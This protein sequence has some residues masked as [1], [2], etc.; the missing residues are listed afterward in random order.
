MPTTTGGQTRLEIAAIAAR[1]TLI[2]INTYDSVAAANN[3]TATHTRA[4]ADT[5]TPIQGKGTGNYLDIDNYSAG[6]DFDINGNPATAV[7]SGRNPAIALNGATW[8]YGPVGLGLSNY[9]HPDTSANIG[10]VTI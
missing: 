7:G 9:Q 6:G 10:E 4:L 5:E 1:N 3:Y 2:A 8:G